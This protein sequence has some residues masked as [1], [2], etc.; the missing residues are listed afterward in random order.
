[1]RQVL[2]TVKRDE[3]GQVATLRQTLAMRQNAEA[4]DGDNNGFVNIPLAAREGAR[5]QSICAR[6]GRNEVSRESSFERETSTSLALPRDSVA[7]A[8]QC[9][10]T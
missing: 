6:S 2:S 4:V 8:S 5:G 7:A 10:G 3:S 9:G 1:M